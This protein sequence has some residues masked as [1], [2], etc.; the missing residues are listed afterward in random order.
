V[1]DERIEL[2]RPNF[3]LLGQEEAAETVRLLAVLI[4]AARTPSAARPTP[5]RKS[6][7]P[8]DLAD[9]SPFARRHGG[10]SASGDAAGGRR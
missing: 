4:H 3:I 5:R 9:G 1:D 7:S 8:Q 10:K 6:P 2:A